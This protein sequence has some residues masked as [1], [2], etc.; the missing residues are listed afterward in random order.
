MNNFQTE[1]I[2]RVLMFCLLRDRGFVRY[3]HSLVA[4]KRDHQLLNDI[5][6]TIDWAIANP[7]RHIQPADDIEA[8]IGWINTLP[9]P[10]IGM[11]EVPF[12]PR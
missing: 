11:D 6:V 9:E 5:S 10:G 8:V 4:G 12:A 7:R 1:S 2:R 3:L